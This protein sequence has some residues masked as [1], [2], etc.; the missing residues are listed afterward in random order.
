MKKIKKEIHL[1]PEKIAPVNGHG[2]GVAVLDTGICFH[3]DFDHRIVAFHDVIQYK[4]FPYDDNGHGTHISGILGGSG[5]S[6][7][8]DFAGIA[9]GCN[10]ISV[11]ILDHHGNGNTEDVLR[12]IDWVL[13][14]QQRYNIRIM[15]ISVGTLPKAGETEKSLLIKAVDRAWDAGIV[16]VCAA[17]NNGPGPRTITTPGISRKVITVGSSDDQIYIDT[18]G[19]RKNNYSGRGPTP[20]CICKPDVVAPGSDIYSCNSRY[21]RRAG[22]FYVSKSGTSMS[23]PVVSGAIALLLN[24]Y[25]YLTNVDVKLLLRERCDDLGLPHSQQGWGKLNVERLLQ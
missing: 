16:V 10:I 12:G 22:S 5:K 2:V 8:G 19:R 18:T 9:P 15:N 23:T 20:F 11:K 6:S 3:P 7:H 25:D 13:Q 1:Y 21:G 4:N 14:N 24:R 17:G